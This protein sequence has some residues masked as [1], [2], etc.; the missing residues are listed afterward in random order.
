MTEQ[1]NPAEAET[2]ESKRERD[3][4]LK[5]AYQAANRRL[6]QEHQDEFNV[7][8]AEEAE[9]LGY[10]WKPRQTAEQKAEAEFQ[11]LLAE[12]PHLAEQVSPQAAQAIAAEGQ[13]ETAQRL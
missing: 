4:A 13:A 8:Y 12:F 1:T 3:K 7:Y 10:E 6:R 2:P 11:R 9:A 5:K